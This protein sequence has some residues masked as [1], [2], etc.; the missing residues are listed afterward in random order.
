MDACRA[1]LTR[2]MRRAARRLVARGT[3]PLGDGRVL[4][5]NPDGR[6]L[7]VDGHDTSLSPSILLR[8]RWEPG[9]TRLFCRMV[10]AGDHVLEVGSNIGWYAL[11]AAER[12]GPKGRVSAFE[13]N[14]RAFELLHTNVFVNGL[15]ERCCLDRRALSDHDGTATLHVAGSFLG[16]GRLRPFTAGDLAWQRQP[17]TAIE[18]ETVTLDEALAG[19]RIDL[20]KIDV[21]GSEPDVFAGGEK[22]FAENESLR[23]IFE[24]TPREHG[25]ELLRWLRGERFELHTVNRLGRTRA[26]HDEHALA[27]FATVDL[28]AVRA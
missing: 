16:S 3:V 8:R 7:Y 19:E 27:E 18:I 14:P 17:D 13:P 2:H 20:M 24:Y 25:P 26:L 9:V 5:T 28:L 4:T 15:W 6:F 21:E 11:L 12:V 22:F 1:S 23:L 10:R